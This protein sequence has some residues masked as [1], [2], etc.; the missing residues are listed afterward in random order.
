MKQDAAAFLQFCVRLYSQDGMR[1]VCLDLQN[2]LGLNVN[3]LLL[4][5]WAA[6]LGYAI[7]AELWR[8][9]QHHIAPIRESAVLPIRALRRQISKEPKLREDLR[10]PIK[11]LLLYAELRA[12]QAEE[13]ALHN[14]MAGLATRAT[15]GQGLLRRNLE[16][17]TKLEPRLE[18][19]L[20]I[21][22]D[23]GLLDERF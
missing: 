16:T 6:R 14:R 5:A 22:I 11:R 4:S 21:T 17:L 2:S 12:E 13:H 19:F 1:A 10:A 8:D 18:E 3:C 23:S 20:R 15:A 9:L 7:S